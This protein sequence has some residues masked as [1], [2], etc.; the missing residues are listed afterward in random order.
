MVSAAEVGHGMPV[1]DYSIAN[2][3]RITTA[4]SR[5]SLHGVSF[6]APYSWRF[7]RGVSFLA[8][9]SWRLHSKSQGDEDVERA[10]TIRLAPRDR[11]PACRYI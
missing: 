10:H 4:A 1:G 11:L 5:V 6:L 8:F 9:Y 3:H 2:I 7:I